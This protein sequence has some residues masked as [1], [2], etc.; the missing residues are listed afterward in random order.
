MKKIS[1]F[2]VKAD[3]VKLNCN[4]YLELHKHEQFNKMSTRNNKNFYKFRV[5]NSRSIV[6]NTQK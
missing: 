3:L 6:K 1:N 5:K 2:I 4:C